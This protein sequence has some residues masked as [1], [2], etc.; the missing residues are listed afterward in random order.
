MLVNNMS[1]LLPCYF[2]RDRIL[3][4]PLPVQYCAPTVGGRAL[5]LIITHDAFLHICDELC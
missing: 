1:Y 3:D 2:A 5:A 4:L